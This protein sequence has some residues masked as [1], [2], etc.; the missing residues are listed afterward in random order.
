VSKKKR[1]ENKTVETVDN[2]AM[3]ESISMLLHVLESKEIDV[4]EEFDYSLIEEGQVE[5]RGSRWNRSVPNVFGFVGAYAYDLVLYIGR[6]LSLLEKKVLVV[7]RTYDCEVVR[8]IRAIEDVDLK[9]QVVDFCGMDVTPG[10]ICVGTVEDMGIPVV[11]FL[12][13]D[14]VLID[15]GE[16]TADSHILMCDRIYCVFNMYRHTA[17][18]IRRAK[19]SLD[20]EIAFV[21]RDELS[22]SSLNARRKLQVEFC[23]KKAS[24]G[25]IFS[26]RIPFSRD[27]AVARFMMEEEQ[28]ADD[29]LAGEALREFVDTVVMEVMGDISPKQYRKRLSAAKKQGR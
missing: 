27:D 17:D 26:F 9:E 3:D 28:M 15:F 7:D 29:R 24:E 6:K 22:V 14:I 21:F 25:E 18:V 12:D 4:E 16:N 20:K 19:F 5:A 8:I 23:E 2:I 10:D 11:S 13:Y 1:K